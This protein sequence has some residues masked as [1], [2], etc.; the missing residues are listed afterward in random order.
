MRAMF[1]TRS[2]GHEAALSALGDLTYL[3]ANGQRQGGWWIASVDAPQSFTVPVVIDS[4]DEMLDA[5]AASPDF[6]Y[7]EDIPD[8]ETT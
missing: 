4:T 3:D 7:V 1:I 5:A 8:G 2:P 6:L